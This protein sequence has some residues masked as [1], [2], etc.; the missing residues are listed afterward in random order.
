MKIASSVIAAL[1]A[2]ASLSV[3]AQDKPAAD[4]VVVVATK[5]KK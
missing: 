5:R 2:G 3:F 1:L 4:S